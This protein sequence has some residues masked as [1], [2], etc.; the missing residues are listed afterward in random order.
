MMRYLGLCSLGMWIVLAGC[1]GHKQTDDFGKCTECQICIRPST[2]YNWRVNTR[3]PKIF[4]EAE[5][6]EQFDQIF[7]WADVYKNLTE[8]HK[9]YV[10]RI[11]ECNTWHTAYNQ[12]NVSNTSWQN[13]W[14]TMVDTSVKFMTVQEIMLKR[15]GDILSR[16]PNTDKGNHPALLMARNLKQELPV[17]HEELAKM[18]NDLTKLAQSD[19]R[20][21][22]PK[23]SINELA[24]AYQR[25]E[26]AYNTTE[27][28]AG[29]VTSNSDD[30]LKEINTS[31]ANLAKVPLRATSPK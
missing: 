28:G 20:I 29:V 26:S 30:V 17:Y 19:K 6:V 18:A 10:S 21:T 4:A 12:C 5:A 23:V 1:C 13:Y 15:L 14:Q 25:L 9:Q 2:S 24:E 8:L 22:F 11:K 7:A 16:D 27:G 31:L 3:E